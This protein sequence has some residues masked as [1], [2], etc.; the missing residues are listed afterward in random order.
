M[1][2]ILFLGLIFIFSI[3]FI[4]RY[5]DCDIDLGD[6]YYYLPDYEA[7]DIGSSYKPLIYKSFS[8]NVIEK[9]IISPIVVKAKNRGNYILVIQTN[10]KDTI[11][12]YFII[13]KK[14][15]SIFECLDRK[16][17]LNFCTEKKIKPL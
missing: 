12:K 16:D 11:K 8:K 5:W 6:N 7:L 4:Y 3:F 2:K 14:N 10:K 13:N 1:K 15:D 17:F 9:I